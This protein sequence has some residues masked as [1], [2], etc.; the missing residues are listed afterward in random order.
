MQ[1]IEHE[2]LLRWKK[3]CVQACI[4]T[5]NSINNIIKL[6]QRREGMHM[7]HASKIQREMNLPKSIPKIIKFVFGCTRVLK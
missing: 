7:V 5:E 3:N 1:E 4:S 2:V 6:M